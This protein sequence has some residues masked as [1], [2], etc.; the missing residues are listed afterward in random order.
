MRPS[1]PAALVVAL[2]ASCISA[3]AQQVASHAEIAAARRELAVAKLDAQL[4]RDTEYDCAR[5]E[6]D[7]EIRVADE[8]V[9]TM[10][11]QLKYFG[12]FNPYAYGQLPA[13][14]F[15][16]AKLLLAEAESRRRVLIDERNNLHRA[17]AS[18]FALLQLNIEAARARLVELSGG[19]VIELD[20][21]QE[22]SAAPPPTQQP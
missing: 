14:H 7:A 6:L 1:L 8:E 13:F 4:Y 20:V 5:R 12:P 2:A 17:H 15:R 3:N 22:N 9:R 18:K 11:R 19:G 10:R 16:N 21:L